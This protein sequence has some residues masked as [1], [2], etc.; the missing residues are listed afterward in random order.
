MI[1]LSALTTTWTLLFGFVCECVKLRV[2][3]GPGCRGRPC[4]EGVL[5]RDAG[6]PKNEQGR[7]ALKRTSEF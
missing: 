5:G 6:E 7:A 3:W 4:G 2:V 1:Y